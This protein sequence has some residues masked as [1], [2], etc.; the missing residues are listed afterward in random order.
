MFMSKLSA[1]VTYSV[2]ETES[3]KL[4]GIL[5]EGT[6]IFRGIKYAEAERFQLPK[7]VVPWVGIKDALVYGYT[8]PEFY[9]R[10][11]HEEFYHMH[12]YSPQNENCHYVNIW[13]QS[14]D[15]NRKRPVIVW[16]HGGG[17]D[18]GSSIEQYAYDGEEMSRYGDI[19]FVSIEYRLNVFGGLDLSM[20]D[21]HYKDSNKAGIGD[22]IAALKWISVNIDAFGGDPENITL[23]GHAGGAPQVMTLLQTP[24]ADRLYNKVA[25]GG[26]IYRSTE[27]AQGWTKEELAQRMAD[28]ILQNLSIAK[29]EIQKIEDIPFLFL[30]EAAYDAKERLKR[31]TSASWLFEPIPDESYTFDYGNGRELR[32]ETVNIPMLFGGDF[33]D[34]KSNVRQKIGNCRKNEWDENTT[35]S[36]LQEMYG[37]KADDLVVAFKEA[38][39]EKRTADVLYID[40]KAR[41]KNLAMAKSHAGKGGK[42]WNWLFTAEF[43]IDGGTIPWHCCD[44][45]YITHNAQYYEASYMPGISE[46][47]QD[48][49]CSAYIAFAEKGDPNNSLLPPWAEV[50]PDSVSTMI[51]DHKTRLAVNHDEKLQR[52]LESW[53]E[54]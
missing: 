15:K 1:P 23:I 39:P 7:L 14:I 43:P 22:I 25:L 36:H 11:S 13:T 10:L 21:E 20:F 50:T 42:G 16:F 30:L 46:R 49:L 51:F 44:S 26:N 32:G 4:R 12:Y 34:S 18:L 45:P 2:V 54:F 38:Y 28:F 52:L 6:Y 8:A 19:V 17:W 35:M 27:I 24:S 9:T 37:Q 31:E 53:Y 40:R 5:K 48:E 3:G 47:I 33:G 41:Y 29:N